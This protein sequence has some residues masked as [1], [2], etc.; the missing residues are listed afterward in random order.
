MAIIVTKLPI[1]NTEKGVPGGVAT[2]DPLTGYIPLSQI[3]PSIG[4]QGDVLSVNNID[5]DAQ[6]NV[7]I[8]TNDIPEL[9]N[10]YYTQG[11][12]NTAFSTAIIPTT[13][14]VVDL[15]LALQAEIAEREGNDLAQSNRINA[16]EDDHVTIPMFNGLDTRLDQIEIDLPAEIQ[17]RID[18]V[19][20]LQSQLN[21]EIQNR[22]GADN[23]LDLRIDDLESHHLHSNSYYANDG[24]SDIQTEINNVGS[25][26]GK[27]VWVTSGS[28]GGATV[29][30]TDKVNMGLIAPDVGNT[31][32]ELSGG[33]GLTIS[34]TS[35][36]IRIANLQI[37]GTFT[38]SGSKGRHVFSDCEFL[39]GVNIDGTT[40]T[41]STFIT[42][43]DCVF[44]NQNINLANLTNCIVYFN[45]CSFNNRRVITTNCTTSPYVGIIA[46]GSL[47]NTLQTQF[48]GGIA[49][50]GRNDYSNGVVKVYST[51]SNFMSVLGVE[52]AFTGS[53]TELR[54]KPTL[55]TSSTQLS[56]SSSLLRTSDKGVANGV[57]ELDANG[58]IPNHHLPPLAL[59][60]PYVVNTIAERDALTVEM[61]DVAIVTNDPTPANN[62]NYIYDADA[63][64]WIKLY[65]P[66]A[67]VDSVNGQTGTVTLYTGDI[68]EGQGA[69]SEPSQ[70]YFTDQRAIDAVVTSNI[71]TDDKAPSTQTVKSYVSGLTDALDT[72][73][74][75]VENDAVNHATITYVDNALTGKV[76]VSDYTANDVLTK[77]LTVDGSGSGLD[78]DKLDNLDSADFV[79]ITGT[80]TI[81][82]DK[83]FSGSLTAITQLN[84]DN[85]T[86]VATTAFVQ[87]AIA[88]FT[89]VEGIRTAVGLDGND[90]WSLPS[91]HYLAGSSVITDALNT[92]DGQIYNNKGIET[93]IKL[94]AGFNNNGTKNNFTST[95]YI[96]ASD[97]LLTAI[98]TLD[99]SL[100]TVAQNAPQI[101]ALSDIANV[102]VNEDLSDDGK[103]LKWDNA[104][105]KWVSSTITIPEGYTSNDA[106][107]DVGAMLELA[108]GDIVFTYDEVNRTIS[109]AV[110]TGSVGITQINGYTD[111]TVNLTATDLSAS[112][113]ASNYLPSAT[114]IKGHL[115]GIDSALLTKASLSSNTFT[116][117]NQYD[118]SYT[119]STSDNSKK[120][121]TTEYVNDKIGSLT[122]A[123]IYKGG[124][125]ASTNSPSL[126]NSLV[127][128]VYAVTAGGTLAGQ[129]LTTGDLIIFKSNVSGGVVASTDF[130]VID[131]EVGVASVN[132]LTGT[133]T[134]NGANI[135]SAVSPTNY[136]I[137]NA[138]L[139]SHLSGINTK[140]GQ[141]PAL[142]S[143]NTWTGTN[144][145]ASTVNMTAAGSVTLPSPGVDYTTSDAKAVSRSYLVSYTSDQLLTKSGNLSGLASASTARTNLGLG[146]VATYATG[147]TNGTVP[148]LT[149]S[150]L[151]AV[152]GSAL[153]SLPGIDLLSDV[154][155]SSATNGQVLSYNGTAWVNSTASSSAV[156]PTVLATA[157]AAY[158]PPALDA[159]VTEVFYRLT[160][161]ASGSVTLTNIP[162]LGNAGLRLTFKKTNSLLMQIIAKSGELIDGSSA[163]TD[164]LQINSALTII[165]DGVNWHII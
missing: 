117:D 101:N 21:A 68:Q 156:K 73:L 72:R 126:V 74:S 114:H 24:L 79:Q 6:G 110:S 131:Q 54:D 2:L 64:S 67:P 8:T 96:G 23:A 84:G 113:T 63:P 160:P 32:C 134:L 163:G 19:A 120:F 132:N 88:N 57:A 93:S 47:L 158:V 118:A 148:V 16:L 15:N 145:F 95:Y 135:D 136:S 138:K 153:T 12:F 4:G 91:S 45:R 98:N 34:G 92:L 62:G 36:R 105:S 10:L 155:I 59:S 90:N 26:Q 89:S 44:E 109:T 129:T 100:N 31:I 78:A 111:P 107:D 121:A 9:N 69:N 20:D 159:G 122:G 125:N 142:S 151:P 128:E 71:N 141:V 143:N 106:K 124:Y 42:F 50:A 52:T 83:D 60:K 49:L 152:G 108:S 14:S 1:P 82:G 112:Y 27:V 3:D 146:T 130:N 40:D 85:T 149:S 61:G 137:A 22:L 104:T 13:Q 97:S 139:D 75:S 81:T 43:Q 5:P 46:E 147:T 33:R 123:L 165:S 103:Y 116:G 76:N 144:T 133:V 162:A 94:S 11:R 41:T 140:L 53:Y 7:D 25:S 157:T 164:M 56:D 29:E 70:L 119:L 17:N 154:N 161:S 38:I 80:Q 66:T 77:L 87:D 51:S 28:F 48:S 30:I 55:V 115:E 99:T 65:N 35:E 86:K 58:L 18:G 102:N 37:E 127:G 150:G 39:G